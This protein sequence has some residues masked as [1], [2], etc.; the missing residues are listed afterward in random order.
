MGNLV[1]DE[2]RDLTAR[3][4]RAGRPGQPAGRRPPAL[5]LRPGSPSLAEL[6]DAIGGQDRPVLTTRRHGVSRRSQVL[7][8]ARGSSTSKVAAGG[9]RAGRRRRVQPGHQAARR[10]PGPAVRPGQRHQ[11][12]GRAAPQRE[13][14]GLLPALDVHPQHRRRGRRRS[15]A[16]RSTAAP[17]PAP[18]RVT[19][20]HQHH[21]GARR[22]RAPQPGHQPGGR[23]A[24]G[25]LLAHRAR[26]ARPVGRAGPTS[27]TSTSAGSPA[28]VWSSSGRPATGWASLSVPKRR[29]VP[30]ASTTATVRPAA[31]AVTGP[32]STG[33]SPSAS[34][35]GSS[36]ATDSASSASGSEPAT[37]PQPANSRI[38][39]G[40]V[41]STW[42][43]R[44]AIAHSPSPAAST[45]PTGPA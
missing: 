38:R 20:Q 33:T 28:R 45:Q 16:S 11:L 3:L 43:Q 39:R 34:R 26:P 35:M 9:Q 25:R 8:L 41:S 30:P 36:L 29:D 14:Q 13:L 44:R 18:G 22:Q 12:L 6:S 40:S 23:T 4:W 42:P 37:M 32:S 31:A 21:L 1:T 27:T 17:A 24:A 15:R 2:D 7:Q 19:R 10:L 5:R